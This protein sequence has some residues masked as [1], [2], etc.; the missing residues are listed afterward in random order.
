MAK[1]ELPLTGNTHNPDERGELIGIGG[2]YTVHDIG[3]GRVVKIPNSMDGSRRFVGG[4]G[5]HIAE[6]KNKHRPLTETAYYRRYCVPHVLR[7]AARYRTLRDV[8]GRP[9]A[10]PG[11]CF[12][13]DRARPL[14]DLIPEATPA[15]V[16]NTLD[17]TADLCQLLWRYGIHDYIWFF[18]VN[19]AVDARGKVVCLDFGEVAF[20]TAWVEPNVEG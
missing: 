11:S 6:M 19:N 3:D 2:Q 9:Q 20:D 10:G 12:T 16:R 13:Q 14:R 5:P 17:A 8:L 4:W 1:Q 18:L 7:L 15:E